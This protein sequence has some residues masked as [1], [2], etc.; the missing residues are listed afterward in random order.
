MDH[1]FGSGATG[2]YPGFTDK[3]SVGRRPNGIYIAR[4]RNVKTTHPEF[5]RGYG[6]QGGSGREGWSRGGGMAGHGAA[7][8]QALIDG[9]GPWRLGATGFGETLPHPDNRV[10]IDPTTRD[11]WGIPAAH[12]DVR[13]RENEIAMERD[14]QLAMAEML[15]AVGCTEIRQYGS[16]NPP[17]HCIHEMGGAR[18]STVPDEGVL[19][20][21]NQAWD[22][23]NLFVT[24]GACMASTA[25]QN[26][27][28]TYMALTARAAAHA[29]EAIGRGE[30]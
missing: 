26:P 18:M 7:F 24:D 27:S 5:L 9:L 10:T 21:W 19:N 15:D 14:M 17:G 25:C 23:P 22:V 2:I 6:M 8:K 3:R 20:E 13:W 16:N 4:F 28:I 12:I 1:H 30:L 11:R 29:V